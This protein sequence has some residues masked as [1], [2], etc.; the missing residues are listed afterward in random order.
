MERAPW[1][2][3]FYERLIG[4]AKRCPRKVLGN[5]RL[6]ADELLIVLMELEATLNS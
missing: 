5:A 3:G 4:T 1:W 2:G 6:N